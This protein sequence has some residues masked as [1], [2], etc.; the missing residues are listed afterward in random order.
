[1]SLKKGQ[2]SKN[3]EGKSKH[4]I[5]ETKK[6]GKKKYTR[7]MGTICNQWDVQI[8]SSALI[9]ARVLLGHTIVQVLL[10]HTIVHKV[11]STKAMMVCTNSPVKLPLRSSNRGCGAA[12]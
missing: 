7:Q 5:K 2:N 6:E 1:M 10:G 12:P 8:I 3:D 11:S 4:I 9:S